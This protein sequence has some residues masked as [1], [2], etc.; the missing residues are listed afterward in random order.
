MLQ[1]QH[2][3]APPVWVLMRGI[4][5]PGEVCITS[6]NRN[7]KGRMGSNEASLYLGSPAAV[8]ASLLE[9]RIADPRPYLGLE[10]K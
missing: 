6:T 10:V 1:S 4:L 9:G 8:A 2:P 7:F 5:G 3:A